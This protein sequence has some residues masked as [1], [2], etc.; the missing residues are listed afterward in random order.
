MRKTRRRL[1]RLG[2]VA[3]A[4]AL[5]AF[6]G[7]GLA[8]P[9]SRRI[10]IAPPD[11]SVSV[12]G[13][14]LRYRDYPGREPAVLLLHGFGGSLSEWEP[15][16]P[17]LPDAHRIS[18]DLVGFGGSD[19]PDISYDLETQRRYL[20]AF[21]DALGISHAVLAGRSMGASLA[22]WTAAQSPDR[23]AAL[24]LIA[25][26]AYPGSLSYPW[27]LSWMYRP[28]FANRTA[29]LLVD[30]DVFRAV[31]RTSIAHQALSVTRSYDQ[32]FADILATI[33]QPTLLLWST[34]DRTVP[35]RFSEAYRRSIPAVEFHEL[36]AAI[37]HGVT[38]KDPAGTARFMQ[39]FLEK[40]STSR[41]SS[42]APVP[43]DAT[44]RDPAAGSSP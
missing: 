19:R 37:G 36:P 43:A 22:A 32:G 29:S 42:L 8:L 31:F 7:A 3:G 30:S 44:N 14:T 11:H 10:P 2:L 5:L 40:L 27:P 20:V 25:P 6:L 28:G 18:L 41:V 17:L 39:A 23:V 13:A 15:V 1:L 24:V 4:L 9:R 16:A 21:M 26:S 35:F 12:L 38:W 33:V 34:G